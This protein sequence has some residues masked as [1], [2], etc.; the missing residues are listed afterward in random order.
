[1]IKGSYSV[2][3]RKIREKIGTTVKQRTVKIANAVYKDVV[4]NTPVL[5]GQLRA[6]WNLSHTVPNYST[7]DS[8]GEEGSP[9][10]ISFKYLRR[11][12]ENPV[13]YL[14]NGKPYAQLIEEGSSKKA[15][16]GVVR[17]AILRNK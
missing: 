14:T 5:T 9:I 3:L 13:I 2:K 8:G 16:Q 11:V 15:P 4:I 10:P 7:V 6:S 1:V 17:V 12:P